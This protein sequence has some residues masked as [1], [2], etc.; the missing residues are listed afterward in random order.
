V[1][2]DT[3]VAARFPDH[4]FA[5][6]PAPI[7][8]T[9]HNYKRVLPSLFIS[10]EARESD[11]TFGVRE[12][13]ATRI[14][15]RK[16]VPPPTAQPTQARHLLA[17]FEYVGRR[18]KAEQAV[19]RTFTRRG[20]IRITGFTLSTVFPFGLF[21]LRRRLRARD[22]RL[23]IYPRVEAVRARFNL[24]PRRR[25]IGESLATRRGQGADLYALRTYQAGDDRRHIDWKATARTRRL[26]VREFAA[27]EHTRAHIV[28]DARRYD[29]TAPDDWATRFEHGITRA[30]SLVAHFTRQG[31]EVAL[32][33]CGNGE[34]SRSANF[35][36]DRA[37]LFSALRRLALV[38]PTQD[39][40]APAD[41]DEVLDNLAA[42]LSVEGA[43][44][45]LVTAAAHTPRSLPQMAHI[46][47][48]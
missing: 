27:D 39:A 23:V 9:L 33:I 36:G 2:R 18:G 32:T 30:A 1:L 15:Q 10:I 12:K 20:E 41:P 4:I 3:G 42:Q 11:A 47:A 25:V 8:A 31:G 38:A 24:P 37:H 13:G 48:Y 21:E 22:V 34:N 19:E 17:R 16:K 46:V 45:I 7:T 40:A 6:E 29:D 44:L 26:T 14:R 43:H 5:G 28:F 35:G